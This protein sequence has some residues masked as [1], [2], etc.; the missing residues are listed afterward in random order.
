MASCLHESNRDTQSLIN[1]RAKLIHSASFI[2]VA[3]ICL[4]T[5]KRCL[6]ES[7]RF[8]GNERFIGNDNNDFVGCVHNN[9]RFKHSL[10]FERNS[11]DTYFN[12]TTRHI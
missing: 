8:C 6:A 7:S 11:N 4:E 3:N 12:Q 5:A 2:G 1:K 10:T 9:L